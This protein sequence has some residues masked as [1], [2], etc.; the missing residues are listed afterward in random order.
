[1]KE[2]NLSSVEGFLIV[3][4]SDLPQLQVPL[5]TAFCIIY[6]MTLAGNLLIMATIY[7]NSHLHTPM[8]FFLTN[9]SFLDISYTSVVFPQMLAH[10]FQ[11]GR[12]ISLT[13]CLLQAYFFMMMVSTEY[14]ILSVMAY[15]R[16]VAIC[17]PLHYMALMNNAVCIRLAAGSWVVSFMVPISH[18]V[19]VSELSFCGSHTINHFFCD[20]TALLKM[21][22]S[23]THIIETLTYIFGATLLMMSFL[24]IIIS[25]VY[26]TKSILKIKSRGGRN[27]AF[28]TCASHLTVVILFYG[29]LVSTYV[30]P[31]STYSMKENKILSLS[32]IA[33]TP[34]CN[35]IIY[36]LKNTEFKS[37]LRR[38]RNVL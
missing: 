19:L 22:C 18:T 15:D 4:F 20:L 9:L 23:N 14:L 29:S 5:F 11:K 36:T 2:E 24:L 31:T 25:Y 27:K 1:M 12:Y 7:S 8:Y 26:I 35:P 3:G 34:L 32:Y 16:Y 17:N 6:L 21:S 28:H 10:F 37:V 33:V 38:P 13:N 30:R